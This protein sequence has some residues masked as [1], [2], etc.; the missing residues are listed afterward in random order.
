MEQ[1]IYRMLTLNRN[2]TISTFNRLLRVKGL[3][4]TIIRPQNDVMPYRQYEEGRRGSIFGMEDLVEYEETEIDYDRLL[5]YNLF[6]EGYAGSNDYDS[7]VS[8]DTFALTLAENKLPI[9]TLIEVNFFGK[10]FNLKVDDHKSLF[11]GV[12]EDD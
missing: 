3:K 11:P 1:A 8:N 7:F 9:S 4:C 5:I 2:A 10:Y 6:K 12:V